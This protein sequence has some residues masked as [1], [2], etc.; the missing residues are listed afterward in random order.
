LL[1]LLKLKD[2]VLGGFIVNKLALIRQRAHTGRP[3]GHA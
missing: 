1:L 3:L 2:Y